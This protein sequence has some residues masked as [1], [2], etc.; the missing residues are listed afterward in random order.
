M[1]PPFAVIS[2][3]E[4]ARPDALQRARGDARI[5]FVAEA[6]RTRLAALYQSGSARL[7]LPRVAKGAPPE[8]VLIN[9]AGGLTGGDA[10]SVDVELGTGAHAV[11]TTQACERVYR[12]AGGDAAVAARLRLGSE[13]HLLWL[14]QETILFDGGRLDRRLDAELAGDATLLAVE[15]VILGRAARGETLRTGLFRDHWRIRRDGRLLFA[16]DLR[17]DW[18]TG[19]PCARPAAL[20]GAGAFATLLLVGEDAEDRLPGVRRAIGENGGASAWN[21]KLLARLFAESGVA[22]RRALA[23]VLIDLLGG[24]A[25]P[26]IWQL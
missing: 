17:L 22:L 19:D 4:P 12:S 14:P 2:R 21:G 15:A 18:E 24:A 10:F 7:R 11:L 6:G 8:A 1:I 13:A 20:A 3:S 16:D 25:L 5:S 26:R 9:T 23:R